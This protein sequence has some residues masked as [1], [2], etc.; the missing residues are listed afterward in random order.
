MAKGGNELIQESGSRKPRV[1]IAYKTFIGGAMKLVELPF[2]VGV[3]ADLTGANKP[4]ETLDER[5]FLDFS[6]GE[7]GKRMK[8]LKPRVNMHVPSTLPGMEGELHVD[9]TFESMD[10]FSPEAIARKVEPLRVLLE[11]R[12]SLKN[13]A[14]HLD[15]KD[16]AQLEKILSDPALLAAM[17]SIPS[18][19]PTSGAGDANQENA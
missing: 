1:H 12:E 7:F 16:T 13:L 10:D 5:R 8:A 15:G 19:E 3:M 17:S 18:Q 9:I 4:E 2:V 11:S 14:N 6:A